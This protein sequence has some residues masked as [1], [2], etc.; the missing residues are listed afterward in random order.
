LQLDKFWSVY[1]EYKPTPR[2]ALRAEINNFDPY[3]FIIERRV[4]DGPRNSGSLTE[5]ETELRNSQVLGFVRAR[6][7]F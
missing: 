2:L 6:L 7:T 1:A 4:F 3:T 5:I